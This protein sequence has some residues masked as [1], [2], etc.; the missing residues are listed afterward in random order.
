MWNSLL[1]DIGLECAGFLKGL[2]Y[3]ATIL[4]CS[5]VL[6]GFDQQMAEVVT[7]SMIEKGVNFKM[8]S[9]PVSVEKQ[10][11]GKLLVKYVMNDKPKEVLSDYFDTVLF[12]IGR[13]ALVEDLKLE[14]AGVKITSEK[15]DVDSN[16][17][18]NVDNIYAVGDVLHKKP[19]L[20]PVAINAGR[21]IARNI[22]NNSDEVMDYE[23]V[24]TT[25]FSPLE[26]GC[27]DLS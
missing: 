24:A 26:Y 8:V 12:A 22:F 27:V 9:K 7:A 5:I 4:V 3:D 15:I 19:G 1:L 25:I 18:T 20:T 17:K 2:G 23:D 16:S 6:R 10:A 21:I 13:Y 11:D 14:N